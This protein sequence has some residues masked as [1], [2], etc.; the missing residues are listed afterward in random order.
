M[1]STWN[2]DMN[3]A[4]DYGTSEFWSGNRARSQLVYKFFPNGNVPEAGVAEMVAAAG[5]DRALFFGTDRTLAVDKPS[6]F[7]S[8]Y[9]VAKFRNTYSNGGAGHSSQFVDMDYF[10]MRSAEAYL[11]AAEADL[12]EDGDLSAAGL[13]YINALRSRA[14]TTS[15]SKENCTLDFI[16]DE[17]S[18]ELY[19]EGFRRTDL[20]RYGY[21]GGEN[22]S[23]YLCEWK[24]G[25]RNGQGFEAFR[26][27]FAIPYEDK[28]A[29]P[30]IIQNAGYN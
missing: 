19:Y 15:V 7:T 5:D 23:K 10:F 16:L 24:G 4:G 25:V 29:N 12:R 14:N 8:G 3:E 11:I 17:R 22:S 6:E 21:F 30:N 27:I 28:N 13:N 20:I 9:S 26:N 2:K 18:R 1:A